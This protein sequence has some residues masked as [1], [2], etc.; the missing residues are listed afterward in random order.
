MIFV[1][2]TMAQASK[3]L[4]ALADDAE[5]IDAAKLLCDADI[6]IVCDRNGVLS[7]VITK[8]EVVAQMSQCQGCSCKTTARSVMQRDVVTCK[9]GDRMDVVWAGMKERG[10]KNLPVIDENSRPVGVLNARDAL[11]AL[12]REAENEEAF[13][14]DYVMT[15]GYH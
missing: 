13:L 3:R 15:V 4:I 14:R 12:L 2:A 11:Q 7:G 9:P 8:T 1:E 6:V 5:L 10:L